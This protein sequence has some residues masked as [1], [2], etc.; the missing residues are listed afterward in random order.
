MCLVWRYR[1]VVSIILVVLCDVYASDPQPIGKVYPRGNHWAVGHLMGKK[2]TDERVRPEDPEGND[3]TSM[4]I[5]DQ[6]QQLERHNKHLLLPVLH[7][8]VR[9]RTAPESML[10]GTEEI[11][12]HK[13][14][15]RMLE[16]RH[17][18]EEVHER[19]RQVK[20][21]EDVL[22]RA[23]LMQDDNES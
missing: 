1:L 2:S 15:Q 21:A 20:L 4:T 17:H 6:D 10:E 3:D 9:G 14:L 12:A 16:E 5:L 7:T 23:L 8:L 22:L 19:D 13:L 18:W 11:D